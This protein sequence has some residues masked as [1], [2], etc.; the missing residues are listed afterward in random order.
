MGQVHDARGKVRRVKGLLVLVLL[1][2]LLATGCVWK[3]V[4]AKT[5]DPSAGGSRVCVT[6]GYSGSIRTTYT[7]CADDY[8]R[9]LD[10][11]CYNDAKIG[12]DWPDSC[13]DVR[14]SDWTL[15]VRQ[16][17]RT[18]SDISLLGSFVV[19]VATG[20]YVLRSWTPRG[21]AG[22][23]GLIAGLGAWFAATI[24]TQLLY[25]AAFFLLPWHG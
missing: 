20:V 6:Y 14:V 22:V 7:T 4:T 15:T 10:L 13:R 1:S 21:W 16:L 19:G 18:A 5:M 2:A 8:G 3:V 17:W 25:W 24:V 9:A 23:V 11:R 12:D